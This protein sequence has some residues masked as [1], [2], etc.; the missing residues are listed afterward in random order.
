MGDAMQGDQQ[1][2]NAEYGVVHIKIH[3]VPVAMQVNVC[4]L[5]TARGLPSYSLC[6]PFREPAT[7]ATP[8]PAGHMDDTDHFDS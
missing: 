5:R 7:V 3:G 1:V 2:A 4:D 6:P 8:A